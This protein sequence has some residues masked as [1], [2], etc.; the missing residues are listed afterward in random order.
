MAISSKQRRLS[1]R[2]AKHPQ[3]GAA[4]VILPVA[5]VLMCAVGGLTWWLL[6]PGVLRGFDFSVNDAVA[7]IRSWGAWGMAG[8]IAL[9]VVHSFLPF[10]AE[11]IALANGLIYG[12][13]VG[14]VITWVGAMLGGSA[15]F[16][17]TRL[18]GRPLVQRLLSEGQQE[19]LAAWSHERGG[20]ALL[21]S[22]LIP[23]IAFNLINYA[24]ALTG[25]SWWTFLWAT[26]LGILPFTIL[27]AI[28]GN[29]MLTVPSWAWL[30]IGA[31]VLL[32][33]LLLDR[34]W[35]KASRQN[36]PSAGAAIAV[37]DPH[38]VSPVKQA[39]E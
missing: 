28:L 2:R 18:I 21:L 37:N 13:L 3:L 19:R 12:P 23:V 9:M 16:G 6:P 26:G 24:A 38:A 20:V 7:L 15:A 30:A 1:H 25:I 34:R 11:V 27:L 39:E 33:C 36:A 29:Q 4:R 14:A 8:S 10:P 35:R 32:A 17:L 31:V 22:R 5:I